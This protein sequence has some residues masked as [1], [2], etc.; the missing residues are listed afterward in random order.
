MKQNKFIDTDIDTENID[1]HNNTE[2][3]I[4][5]ISMSSN[6][7]NTKIN[8][9]TKIDT[10][11]LNDQDDDHIENKNMK[12]VNIFCNDKIN[13]NSNEIEYL[14]LDDLDWKDQYYTEYPDAFACEDCYHTNILLE[15]KDEEIKN[16]LLEIDDIG[17]KL[18]ISLEK[19]KKLQEKIISFDSNKVL[20][21][22]KNT[23]KKFVKITK[24]SEESIKE[25]KNI[26]ETLL[27]MNPKKVCEFINKNIKNYENKF[28]KYLN[29]IIEIKDK[30]IGVTIASL[31]CKYIFVKLI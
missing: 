4:E 21:E 10:P 6:S 5:N 30:H 23:N 18:L 25:M 13:V 28:S 1:D 24:I 2:I 19:Q 3:P 29:D 27:K 11:I 9:I 31:S 26:I 17:N 22:F 20:V 8:E 12:N 15:K 7:L 14:P 16:S